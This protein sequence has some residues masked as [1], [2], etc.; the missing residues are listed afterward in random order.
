MKK[1]YV[2]LLLVLVVLVL[3]VS[4]A[5]DN[6][7][8]LVT[9]LTGAEEVPGPGDPDGRGLTG[10]V[11]LPHHH[12]ICV[13]IKVANIAPAT[14]AHVHKAPRGVAGP[15]VVPLLPPTSGSSLSCTVIDRDL[16]WGI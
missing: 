5:A 3:P 9:F 7:R 15:V 16:F 4:V 2:L 11:L 12:A 8:V 1:G 14:A 6:N 13:G 10:V